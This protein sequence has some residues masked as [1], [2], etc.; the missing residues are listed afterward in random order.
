M[1][2]RPRRF[3]KRSGK[4]TWRKYGARAGS[5]AYKAYK[6]AS[7]IKSLINTEYKYIDQPVGAALDNTVWYIVPITQCA[8]GDDNINRNG[9]SILLK[10]INLRL[11]ISLEGALTKANIRVMLIRYNACNGSNPSFSELLDTPLDIQS[12]RNLNGPVNNYTVFMDKRFTMDVD[13]KDEIVFDRFFKVTDHVKYIGTSA[14]T[15]SLGNNNYFWCF[16]SDNAFH[17]S[18]VP[19]VQGYSRCRFID[20]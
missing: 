12:F 16:L 1:R 18:D 14:A 3:R 5:L 8:Q 15:A 11:K 10:S 9:K 19:Y 2:R 6:T 17:A 13:T 20:N 7:F 4:Y